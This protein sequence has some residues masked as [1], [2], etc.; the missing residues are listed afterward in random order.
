MADMT[1]HYRHRRLYDPAAAFPTPIEPG[2]IA[3]NS[4]NRQI[5]VGDADPA[6]PGASKPLIGVRFFDV[7][8]KYAA[9]EFVVQAG[10]LYRAKAAISPGAFNASQWDLYNIESASKAYAD[11][12]DADLNS[13]YQQADAA[14]QADINTRVLRS[15]DTMA[16]PLSV[17]PPTDPT[18]ATT[19]LYVDQQI[20]AGGLVTLPAS[21]ITYTPTGAVSSTNVQAAI[22]ELDA[23]KTPYLSPAFTGTPTAPSPPASDNSQKLA[24]TAWVQ[25]YTVPYVTSYVTGQFSSNAGI[26]VPLMDGVAAVGSSVKFA[27]DD[28]RHPS[29][30]SRAP[31]DSPA[32][33][34]NPTAPTQGPSDNSTKVATTAFVTNK[35]AGV[36]GF[37][38]LNSPAFTGNP[39]AP[40]AGAGDNDTS[41]ATTAFV[42]AA[43]ANV[44][45]STIATPVQ[46]VGGATPVSV[47]A[48]AH[49]CEVILVGGGGG[50]AAGAGGGGGAA[51]MFAFTGL[52][53]GLTMNL[54]I[55]APGANGNPGGATVLSAGTQA[56]GTL[57][58]GGGGGA[59]VGGG[60]VGGVS[61]G[62]QL[63]FNGSNAVAFTTQ[64]DGN[65]YAINLSGSAGAGFGE[66]G[67]SSS[68]DGLLASPTGYGAGGAANDFSGGAGQGTQGIAIFRWFP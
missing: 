42:Q 52:T 8:A 11:A 17:P 33:T 30:T 15:G 53:P 26:S 47:P 39:T 60:P 16:G 64:I 4:A 44:A 65:N 40:T 14:L 32:F 24:T 34:G 67:K 9:N 6:S 66:G 37:A 58:A 43:V 28:H 63:N 18:H 41:I 36:G 48:G 5:A 46:Y 49:K 51:L 59:A 29:D 54:S 50:G 12:G 56:I 3:I 1:S 23:E 45:Q 27:R 19:K 7:K 2:E 22:S 57:T 21:S 55:G 68:R 31:L 20:A 35:F 61:S 10:G 62:G 38:P 13:A 25:N